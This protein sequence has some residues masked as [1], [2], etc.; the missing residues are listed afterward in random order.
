MTKPNCYDCKWRGSVPGD[1]HSCCLHPN[2]GNKGTGYIE[3]LF[4]LLLGSADAGSTMGIKLN[5]HGVRNGWAMWPVNFDPIWVENCD[6]F[7]ERVKDDLGV[8]KADSDN[9]GN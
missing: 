6:C 1:C 2:T 7:E 5:S 8:S 4:T 9:G 3:N